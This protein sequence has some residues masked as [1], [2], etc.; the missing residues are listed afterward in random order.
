MVALRSLRATL[1]VS[2]RIRPTFIRAENN[3]RG[4]RQKRGVAAKPPPV[5]RRLGRKTIVSRRSSFLSPLACPDSGLI[6]RSPDSAPRVN[7][8]VHLIAQSLLFPCRSLQL[9]SKP[10]CLGAWARYR[11]EGQRRDG[12]QCRRTPLGNPVLARR[13]DAMRIQGILYRRTGMPVS[14]DGLSHVHILKTKR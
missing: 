4:M 8:P 14:V 2:P 13:Q 10:V 9:P 1:G 3:V 7:A 11:G 6:R 12:A 5:S